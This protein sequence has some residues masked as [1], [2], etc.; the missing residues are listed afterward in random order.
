MQTIPVTT[1]AEIADAIINKM[2]LSKE[3][4]DAFIGIA[5]DLELEPGGFIE[6]KEESWEELF[7]D[8]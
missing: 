7:G 5:Q 6:E 8:G 1:K 4:Y 3:Q 2:H